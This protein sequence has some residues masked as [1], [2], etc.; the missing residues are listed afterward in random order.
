MCC[1][2]L[3][4]WIWHVTLMIS[5]GPRKLYAPNIMH[6][7][8]YSKFPQKSFHYT[9]YYSLYAVS[10]RPAAGY[11][12]LKLFVRHFLFLHVQNNDRVTRSFYLCLSMKIRCPVSEVKDY[13][14]CAPLVDH[15]ERTAP[16]EN[17]FRGA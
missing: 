13:I 12:F 9:W 15:L 7:L 3:A 16:S 5:V 1:Y 11:Y 14:C 17:Q 2:V 6:S 10:I 4:I 8:F